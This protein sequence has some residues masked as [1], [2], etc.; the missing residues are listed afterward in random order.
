MRDIRASAEVIALI[1]TESLR[2]LEKDA[3]RSYEC[4]ECG[5]SGLT[6][7]ATSV[8]VHRYRDTALVKLAHARCSRPKVVGFDADASPTARPQG[9]GADM[10]AMTLVLSYPE[11][12]TV[13]PLLL[14][15]HRVEAARL[16]PGGERISVTMAAVLRR[17]LALMST[18]GEMPDLAEGWEL[19]RPDRA[20]ALL[21]VPGGEV[22]YDGGC[23]QPDEWARLVDAVGACV[24]LVGTIGLYAISGEELTISRMHHMLNEA[25]QAG[26]LAGGLVACPH[27]QLSGSA[28][29]PSPAELASKIR[30]FWRAPEP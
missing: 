24:V 10:R 27:G 16:T 29:G 18:D 8:V 25:A 20:S 12:P 23:D 4:A 14:L 30:R 7:D 5:S 1:G 11:E 9:D 28:P 19:L 3:F 22:A 17:G 21:L 26:S 6:T 13:R 2:E 15:E